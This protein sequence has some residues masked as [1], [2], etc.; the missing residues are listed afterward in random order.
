MAVLFALLGALIFGWFS[1]K[2]SYKHV[3]PLKRR[4]C[5]DWN[6]AKTEYVTT[7]TS[8]RKIAEKYHISLT[9]VAKHASD[10]NWTEAR[11]QFRNDTYTGTLNIIANGSAERATKILKV[12][13]K[14]LEKV[15]NAV[16]LVEETDMRAYKQMTAI[17]K[18]I[19]DIQVMDDASDESNEMKIIVEGWD[20][21][22]GE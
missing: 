17:L 18:D 2:I 1:C 5:V 11:K 19:K 22:W 3:D 12:S 8:Y 6:A 14:I 15:E 9:Q 16:D 7:D 4:N 13:D 20:E 21:N 10:E